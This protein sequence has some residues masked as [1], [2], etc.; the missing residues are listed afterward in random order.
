MV[1]DMR[2]EWSGV[3]SKDTCNGQRKRDRIGDI[4][5][6]VYYDRPRGKVRASYMVDRMEPMVRGHVADMVDREATMVRMGRMGMLEM[7]DEV[8]QGQRGSG[9]TWLITIA[10][11][12]TS[13]PFL[14]HT[15]G[16]A[17][18]WGWMS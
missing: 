9:G 6:E 12:L 13:F 3:Q 8:G 5:R 17:V 10:E 7:E 11:N 1:S 18:W 2:S 4:V 16:C 15:G 14:A